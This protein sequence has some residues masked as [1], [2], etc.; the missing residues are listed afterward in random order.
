MSV[1][2]SYILVL[3]SLPIRLDTEKMV[4]KVLRTR[5][6]TV[7]SVPYIYKHIDNKS[8]YMVIDNNDRSLKD[9]LQQIGYIQA[10]DPTLPTTEESGIYGEKARSR[11]WHRILNQIEDARCNGWQ[12]EAARCLWRIVIKGAKRD[13]AYLQSGCP[14]TSLV[15]ARLEKVKHLYPSTSY[16][17]PQY[18]IKNAQTVP[19][20]WLAQN[21][22]EE[23]QS[24]VQIYVGR[25]RRSQEFL[26]NQ[27][28][29]LGAILAVT[30]GFHKC[31]PSLHFFVE[32]I[33][34]TEFESK[35]TLV[36]VSE[37]E[38]ATNG[39]NRFV[40]GERR[41]YSLNRYS[42]A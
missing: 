11:A 36:K 29:A 20:W 12:G 17:G 34:K 32:G 9:K 8:W 1:E 41:F 26:I 16:D 7:H 6:I 23:I 28:K 10:S 13:A 24:Q 31:S 3:I 37:L 38:Q 2:A 40:K 18:G 14:G 27:R 39:T 21:P 25:L 30:E 42:P 4:D 15:K 35:A 22:E 33:L 19:S 5:E